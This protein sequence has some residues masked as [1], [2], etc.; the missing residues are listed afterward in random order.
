MAIFTVFFC[1]TGSNAND[2]GHRN[3]FEGELI[4]TLA[5]NAVG[6][7]T[8]DYLQVDGVGS[9]N[10]SEWMKH[11]KDD[12]YGNTLGTMGRGIDSNMNH[13]LN[14]LRGGFVD[15]GNYQRRAEDMLS[16]KKPSLWQRLTTSAY[17]EWQRDTKE[18]AGDLKH[19][20][21]LQRGNITAERRL[22]PITQVNMV[23]WSRGGVSCFELA[24]RMAKDPQLSNI[25]VNIF[26]CDPVPGGV[27]AF[28]DYKTLRSNVKQIVC[29]F[30]ADERSFGFKARM[31]RLH[32]STKYYT[33]YMPG[34]H[35]TLVGNS[36][37][38]GGSSGEKRLNGPGNVTRDFMEK[39]LLGWGSRLK[40]SS[41][42]NLNRAEILALY[43]QMQG[44]QHYYQ[45]QHSQV[46]TVKN[47]ILW[48]GKSRIGQ[49][50]ETWMGLPSRRFQYQGITQD[51]GECV[52]RHHAD[53]LGH[54]IFALHGL[55]KAMPCSINDLM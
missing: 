29:L 30:A 36:D 55:S 31:P 12:T 47:R 19:A 28:K 22:N 51:F 45:N 15:K 40:Q 18:L 4:S 2:H 5:K 16:E 53:V 7:E 49:K 6:Q 38:T 9:G 24:N 50:R 26:A 32:S 1:G 54:D 43:Q 39:V 8:L 46:Y 37:T 25:P 42:K 52:N 34:R 41:L 13:V 44:N 10:Q 20:M 48:S 17:E 11:T 27:N 21:S 14:V 33:S 35:A 23:G 3:Y